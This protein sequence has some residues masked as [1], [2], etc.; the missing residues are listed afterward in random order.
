MYHELRKRALMLDRLALLAMLA[1][2]AAIL[3]AAMIYQFAL[4]EIPCPLCLLQRFA[5]FG[6]CFGL[7]MQLRPLPFPPPQAG[8]GWEG[9]AARTA[10]HPAAP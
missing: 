2:V 3:T 7:M 8:E 1:I 4:G 9:V 6:C 10:R 5:M